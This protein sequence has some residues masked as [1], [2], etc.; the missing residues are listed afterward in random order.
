MPRI[1]ISPA[2][3]SP[4]C[5]IMVPALV[6][7]SQPLLVSVFSHHIFSCSSPSTPRPTGSQLPPSGSEVVLRALFATWQTRKC[8]PLARLR[9]DWVLALQLWPR[10][11]VWTEPFAVAKRKCLNR[12]NILVLFDEHWRDVYFV[13]IWGWFSI[14]VLLTSSNAWL[15]QWWIWNFVYSA[16]YSSFHLNPFQYRREVDYLEGPGENANHWR[17]EPCQK[18]RKLGCWT[19][20]RVHIAILMHNI[21]YICSLHLIWGCFRLWVNW[22]V[23]FRNFNHPKYWISLYHPKAK[24]RCYWYWE[25][26]LL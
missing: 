5:Q 2:P 26:K 24:S 16:I 18:V 21:P 8:L 9:D 3:T 10:P 7:N 11:W 13:E 6:R 25:S 23:R 22:D 17:I 1:P 19:K 15:A 20:S 14:A 12:T 4:G